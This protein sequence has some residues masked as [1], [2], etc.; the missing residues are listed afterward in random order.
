MA[1]VG[2]IVLHGGT[3]GGLPER[4]RTSG[5]TISPTRPTLCGSPW[6]MRQR[7]R[8]QSS[9][10]RCHRARLARNRE[11]G[12][13][14]HL[15]PTTHEVTNPRP[16]QVIYPEPARVKPRFSNDALDVYEGTIRIIVEIAPGDLAREAHLV[17][18]LTAQACTEEICLP[19]ADLELPPQ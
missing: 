7:W 10:R 9:H 12:L 4:R 14:G 2:F 3:T 6:W 13:D 5:P 1:V 8:R 16:L 11:P 19:P 15:I 17:G 18:T